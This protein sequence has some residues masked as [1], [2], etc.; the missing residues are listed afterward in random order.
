TPSPAHSKRSCGPAN[1]STAAPHAS[2]AANPSSANGPTDQTKPKTTTC[3]N[4][5]TATATP[6]HTDTGNTCKPSTT[7]TST[8]PNGSPPT[9]S[10]AAGESPRPQSTRG[11]PADSCADDTTSGRN[12][13]S[14]TYPTH[15]ADA[16]QQNPLP[17]KLA[18]THSFDKLR[19]IWRH[20][21]AKIICFCT[22]RSHQ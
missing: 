19:L 21:Y 4:A 2:N 15:Y 17:E 1:K 16:T 7:N 6:P 8:N 20:T 10:N 11:P 5:A 18:S 13:A 12:D 9:T 14:T 22:P 3:G